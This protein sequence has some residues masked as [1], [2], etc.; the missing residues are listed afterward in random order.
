MRKGPP[1]AAIGDFPLAPPCEGR[2]DHKQ[3]TDPGALVF[4]II[5]F[6]LAPLSGQRLA[7]FFDR[8][9]A[10]FIYT[11]PRPSR[12]VGPVRDF[13]N[14]LQGTDEVGICRGRTTP[15]LMPPGVQFVFFNVRRPVSLE[16]RSTIWSW[17]RSSA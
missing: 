1:G 15:G 2:K 3:G 11:A 7:G 14:V 17:T 4:R 8:L 16:R 12:I 9:L 5:P 13:P 10:G 6:R